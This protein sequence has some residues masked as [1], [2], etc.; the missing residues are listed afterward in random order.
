VEWTMMSS[1]IN[2]SWPLQPMV[3]RG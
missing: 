3:A 1:A 2:S